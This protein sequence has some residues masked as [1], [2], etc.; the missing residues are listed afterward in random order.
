[1]VLGIP[2]LRTI[3]ASGICEAYVFEAETFAQ[4]MV[5]F[6][7]IE[8]CAWQMCGATLAY[9]N[10]EPLVSKYT[11]EELRSFFHGAQ[12]AITNSGD[13]V[14]IIGHTYLVYGSLESVLGT[15]A[16]TQ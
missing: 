12:V 10:D 16:I 6:P 7:T 8:A 13:D 15:R 3:T 2:R 14:H 4:L 1:M 11:F 5:E 9:V